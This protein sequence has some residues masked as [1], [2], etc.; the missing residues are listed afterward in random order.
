MLTSRDAPPE[1][2]RRALVAPRMVPYPDEVAR[3]SMA[4]KPRRPCGCGKSGLKEIAEASAAAI[5]ERERETLI[6]DMRGET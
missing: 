5:P 3:T 2:Y 1:V 6:R 4:P